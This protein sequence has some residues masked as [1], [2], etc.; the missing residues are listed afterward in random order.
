MKARQGD[1]KASKIG[2]KGPGYW[3]RRRP[4][5]LFSGLIKCGE[6]GGGII[7]INA[8]RVGCASARNKGTCDNRR[9]MKREDLEATILNGLQ[10]HLMDPALCEVFAEEYTRHLN[11]IRMDKNASIEA[12][13]AELIRIDRE[14]NKLIDAICDG[15]PAINVKDRMWELENRKTELE[16]LIANTEEEPVLIHPAMSKVY[17][18]QVAS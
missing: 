15:V 10:H 9:T 14:T 12:A 8:E 7:N 11:K 18:D 4:R 6:C 3:D 1:Q 16:S 17:R 13:K 5:Y 2:D